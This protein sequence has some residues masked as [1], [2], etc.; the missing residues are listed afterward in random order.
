MRLL[1]MAG[2]AARRNNIA[3]YNCSYQPVE[4]IDSFCEAL[5]ISMS[6]CGVG[7]SV[8]SQYVENFPRIKRQTGAQPDLF[9][10]ED[11][12]EGWADALRSGLETWFEGGDVRFDSRPSSARPA[13]RC[14]S[15]AAAPPAPSRC[16][17][18]S[19]SCARADPGAPGLA[20]CARSTPTT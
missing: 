2:P 17:R 5:I 12:A 9:V 10:V 13:R 1:A 20:S 4:S 16:A 8:E 11:S 18:C 7:F 19:T 6:G 14:G 15:R 3:I